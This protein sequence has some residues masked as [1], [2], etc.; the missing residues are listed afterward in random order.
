M[1]RWLRV[2]E[3]SVDGFSGR[4]HA[5]LCVLGEGARDPSWR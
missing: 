2:G 5:L 4:I 1:C 3:Q